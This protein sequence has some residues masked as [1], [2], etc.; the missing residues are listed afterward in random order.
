MKRQRCQHVNIK[1][2][3]LITAD[4]SV[5]HKFL[6]VAPEIAIVD[7]DAAVLLGAPVGSQQPVHQLLEKKFADLQRRSSRPSPNGPSLSPDSRPLHGPGNPRAGP[8][9]GLLDS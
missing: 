2:C 6:S 5:I 1:K 8:G 7:P 3:E 9:P 4:Q